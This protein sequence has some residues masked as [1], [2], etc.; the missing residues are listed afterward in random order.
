MTNT[1]YSQT[2]TAAPSG[3]NYYFAVTTN[4]LPPGLTLNNST[5]ALTGT[6]T[7]PGNYTF[8]ISA[9]GFGTC[10]ATRSYNV[11][12][13]G[14]CTPITITPNLPGGTLGTAYSQQLSASGGAGPYT[15]AV[16]SGALPAGLMLNP[17][18]G[19]ITGI[20][21]AGGTS[22][23]TIRATGQGGCT[24]T[25]VYVVSI[26]CAALTFTPAAMPPGTKGLNYNQSLSVSP[27][28]NYTFSI[29]LGSLPPGYTMNSAG[30]ISGVTSQTGTYTFT[31]K[32]LSGACQG[33]KSY[34]LVIGNPPA[35]LAWL[36]D[37]DGD[38]KADPTLWNPAQ[39]RWQIL[40]SGRGGDQP[41]RTEYWGKAGDVTL[42][43]D[44]DGDGITDLAVFS[45][46]AEGA[47]TWLIKNSSDGSVS[48]KPWGLATDV[49]V[50]GD[51]DGDGKTDIAVWRGSAGA[52]YII[53]SSDGAVDGALWGAAFAPYHDLAVPGDYDGDG[54]T[55]L[56]VFRRATG[57]WYIRRSSDGQF[58]AQQWGQATDVPVAADYDGDGQTDIAV[59][60]PADGNWLILNS[61]TNT[62][63]VMAWGAAYAPYHDQ[64]APADYDG[65]GQADLAVWRSATGIW[66]IALSSDGS[67][68]AYIQGQTGDQPLTSRPKQ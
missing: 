22:S 19:F 7:A 8:V 30:A 68:R 66:Y 57:T 45:S 5:G 34:T 2:I 58:R 14:T 46:N 32:A 53:R 33:T 3:G 21:T 50:P 59:W 51:Y 41:A 52:W 10:T 67:V 37:Y 18:T 56:A 47:A 36:G 9:T 1:A 31:V 65:D 40:L 6:P 49:P 26:A 55:D 23:F 64:S 48:A 43:G 16:S 54:L 39:G 25:R 61:A 24:G 44:Y 38:G 62:S 35:A 13:T 4:V 11:L 29:L 27:A 28:G 15:Y 63:R 20:P 42:L 12:I 60:R 17:A